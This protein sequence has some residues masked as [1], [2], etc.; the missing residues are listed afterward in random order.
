MQIMTTGA[1]T[2][3]DCGCCLAPAVISL[4]PLCALMVRISLF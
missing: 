3:A 1:D 4:I 2:S